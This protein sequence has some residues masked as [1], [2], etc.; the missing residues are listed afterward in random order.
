MIR[1]PPRSTQSRSSAASDVY[2]R[3]GWTAT[4][5]PVRSGGSTRGATE[6]SASRCGAPASTAATPRVCAS[7]P[8]AA[9]WPAP[10]RS[11]SWPRATRS[12]CRCATRSAEV[13]PAPA[14]R[15]ELEL[16]PPALGAVARSV[17]DVDAREPTGLDEQVVVRR[18]GGAQPVRLG[19]DVRIGLQHL[20]LSRQL[21]QP[22]LHA[23]HL[24]R[25][26][27]YTSPSPRDGLLSR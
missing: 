4:A 23:Q 22:H 21:G 12:S 25:C 20:D 19:V 15:A 5:T 10:T 27:L 1:R 18:M 13:S 16:L 3:Q 7:S 8:A 11:Q 14:A 2:K 17:L 6:S 26:L 24:E 9:S